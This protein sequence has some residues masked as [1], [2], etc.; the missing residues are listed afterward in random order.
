MFMA[1]VIHLT[2]IE[3]AWSFVL[4][5]SIPSKIMPFANLYN[6]NNHQK[7]QYK[8]LYKGGYASCLYNKSKDIIIPVISYGEIT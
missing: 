2:P 3:F 5:P 8:T 6:V 4:H 1:G 7:V